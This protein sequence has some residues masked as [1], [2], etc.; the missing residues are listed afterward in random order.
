MIT[1]GAGVGLLPTYATAIGARV[2]PLDIDL[3]RSFNLASP[4]R[5]PREFPEF[6]ISSSGLSKHLIRQ[7]ILGSGMNL[8]H[9]NSLAA[10]YHGEPII[11]FF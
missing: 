9:P 5:T 10:A 2:V 6:D 1:K 3:C 8:F 4:T 7:S 11:N